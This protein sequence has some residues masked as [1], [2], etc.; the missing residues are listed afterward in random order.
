MA[1][2]FRFLF[3]VLV[4]LSP[5]TACAAVYHVAQSPSASDDNAGSEDAPWRTISRAVE[6]LRPGDTV[7]IHDGVYREWV[8]PRVSGTADAPISFVGTSK[9]K[10]ILTGADEIVEW[11]PVPE[12]GNVYCHAPWE[13][14]FSISRDKDGQPVMHHP[15]DEAH[16][17]I[18]RAEQV[19]V[20]GKLL[21]Q[22]LKREEMAEGTFFVDIEGKTLFVCLR[23]GADPREH[24]VE[25][26]AR[27]WVFGGN[28]WSG[29]GEADFIRL[30]NVT[31]RH[32]ANFAQRGALY[33]SGD[34]WHI[35]NVTV[36]WT[37]GCG[38]SMGGNGLKVE[39]FIS[40]NNGQMGIG[41]QPTNAV[42]EDIQ[43]FDNNRKGFGWGWEAGGMK[44][45]HAHRVVM[46]RV[47]A[48]RNDGP[49]IWFDIDNRAC[50][51]TE[52]FVHDNVGPGI[53]VEIS[54]REGFDITD[55]LCVG[56]GF[57]EKSDWG[58]AGILLGESQ[59]CRV[60]RNLCLGNREGIAIRM[61]GPRNCSSI[62]VD[63]D[64]TRPTLTYV[65]GK[66]RIEHNVLAFNQNWQ[67]A[68]Y[69]DNPFFGPH[70][71]AGANKQA[72]PP[73]DPEKLDLTI[74][75]NLY[76]GQGNQG[77]ILYGASWRPKHQK[78]YS[79]QQWQTTHPFDRHSGF[80]DPKI[81]NTG[82]NGYRLH[83]SSPARRLKAVPE[84]SPIGMLS[85]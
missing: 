70:P 17:L 47:E 78:F 2:S 13:H 18:G 77:L 55:N 3:G 60:E 1:M 80:A 46:R 73:L 65:T 72:K 12:S 27:G 20:D 44:F 39:R 71:S 64:G 32:A 9:E 6:E 58:A 40:R 41:G 74:D 19:I 79:L 15:S 35:A 30:G 69:A 22:V 61:Q 7:Y 50:A 36:E 24:E 48:A 85:K 57:S 84:K 75:S 76:F 25:A 38:A 42:L 63:T 43:L 28:P 62:E 23:D 11:E 21:Q 33:V 56:N 53:F 51:V 66:H 49:G 4:V 81:R 82:Q 26:S 67:L 37:N 54:G 14:R 16:K 34:G 29:K 45:T 5:V 68:F 59:E 83:R 10:V 8:A 52:S 31:I